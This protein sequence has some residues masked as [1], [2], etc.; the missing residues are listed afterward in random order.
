MPLFPIPD[1]TLALMYSTVGI[2]LVFAFGV[3]LVGFVCGGV[4]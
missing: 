1:S 3:S 4:M 2:R